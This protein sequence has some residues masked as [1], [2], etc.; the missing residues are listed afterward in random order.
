MPASFFLRFPS[1]FSGL[2]RILPPKD[3]KAGSPCQYNIT[4]REK[5]RIYAWMR[6][7]LL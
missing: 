1:E 3:A 7:I 6:H 4:I 5:N 2:K